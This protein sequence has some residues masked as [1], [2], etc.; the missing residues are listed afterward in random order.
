MI[1]ELNGVKYLSIEVLQTV[2]NEYTIE[3]L[4]KKYEYINQGIKEINTG[5][6]FN[7]AFA[8]I[9]IL[10]PEKYVNDFSEESYNL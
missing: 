7:L 3:R 8:V 5:G 2:K 1:T 4:C 9:N 6:F 10:V